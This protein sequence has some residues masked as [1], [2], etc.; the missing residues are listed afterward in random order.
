MSSSIESLIYV[1]DLLDTRIEQQQQVVDEWIARLE[2][3]QGDGWD[4]LTEQA[5][6]ILKRNIEDL[7]QLRYHKEQLQKL[8][9]K[10]ITA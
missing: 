7:Q 4:D 9:D 10:A 3:L 2:T 1:I 8:K 5:S 6:R